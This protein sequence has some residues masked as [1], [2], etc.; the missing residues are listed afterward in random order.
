MILFTVTADPLG[1]FSALSMSQQSLMDMLVKDFSDVKFAK[2]SDGAFFDIQEW[3]VLRIDEN[4]DIK[5]IQMN[6]I[7]SFY[8]PGP[9]IKTSGFQAGGS[10]DFQYVPETVQFLAVRHMMLEGVIETSRLSKF[11]ESLAVEGNRLKGTFDIKGL[12]KEMGH[13]SISNNKLHGS[14]AIDYLPRPMETFF[15][16]DNE[17]S[18]TVNLTNLPPKLMKLS[19]YDNYLEGPLVLLHVPLT[20]VDV[21]IHSNRFDTEKVVLDAK[22]VIRRFK[23]DRCFI[24]KI[25]DASGAVTDQRSLEF[26]PEVVLEPVE[27]VGE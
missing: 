8:L 3:S 22:H 18:G 5:G 15:A 9:S 24:G 16:H 11:L 14:L 17:F 1:R 25:F 20:L 10:I 13:I 21:E 23:V 7:D 27:E 6:G 4:G 2:D 19:L 12:P 26:P